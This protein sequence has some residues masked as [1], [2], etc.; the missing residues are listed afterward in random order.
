MALPI[1]YMQLWEDGVLYYNIQ[2]WIMMS[3]YLIG[4]T[5]AILALSAGLFLWQSN[6]SPPLAIPDEPP[7]QPDTVIEIPEAAIDAPQVGDAPPTPPR[8]S[9]LSREE[10]RFNRYDLD[11]NDQISRIEMMASRTKAFRK[12]DVDGNNLLTFE[13]WAISTSDRF[14]KADQNNNL[15]LTRQE[16]LTT[17]SKSSPKPRCKC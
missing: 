11:R 9:K 6:A 5:I 10:R 12:L 2:E 1:F 8:A 15:L 3:K 4:G 14:A 17:K 13:E 16:F 7:P